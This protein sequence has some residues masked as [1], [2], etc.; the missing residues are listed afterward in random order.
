MNLSDEGIHTTLQASNKCFFCHH[1]HHSE[2]RFSLVSSVYKNVLSV[3][4]KAKLNIVIIIK[5]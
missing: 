5:L 3:V 4:E 1:T 2:A